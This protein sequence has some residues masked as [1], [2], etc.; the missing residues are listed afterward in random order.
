MDIEQEI[1]AIETRAKA[2]G[3]TKEDLCRRGGVSVSTFNRWKAGT[4]GPTL[5]KLAALESVIKDATAMIENARNSAT[6]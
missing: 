2:A 1:E 5:R 6:V 3:M 4:T